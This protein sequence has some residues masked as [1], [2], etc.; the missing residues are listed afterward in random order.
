MPVEA[1]DYLTVGDGELIIKVAGVA[2][3]PIG[4]RRPPLQLAAIPLHPGFDIAGTVVEF[5]S[6]VVSFTSGDCVLAL[7]TG[8]TAREGAFRE[9]FV[10]VTNL[11]TSIPKTLPFADAAVLPLGLAAAAGL[12]YESGGLGLNLP[13][14]SHGDDAQ[15]KRTIII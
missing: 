7:A 1:V 9:Y 2:L 15:D 5:G 11:V 14:V 3:N 10:V 4:P 13:R 8:F 6:G 12:L